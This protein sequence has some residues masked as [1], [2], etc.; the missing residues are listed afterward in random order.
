MTNGP[1]IFV[2]VC[3]NTSNKSG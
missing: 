3:F 1:K 2:I